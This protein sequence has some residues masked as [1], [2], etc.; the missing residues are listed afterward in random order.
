MPEGAQAGDLI[1]KP[2]DYKTENGSYAADCGTLI[3]LR[4]EPTR[5]R[6]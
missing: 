5:S 3:W 2:C 1:L 6:G 4:N